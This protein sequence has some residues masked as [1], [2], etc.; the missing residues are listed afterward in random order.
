MSSIRTPSAARRCTRKQREA[1][2]WLA[3]FR[4]AGHVFVHLPDEPF[5]GGA[6]RLLGGLRPTDAPDSAPFGPYG[7]AWVLQAGLWRGDADH[8][9]WRTTLRCQSAVS[10]RAR[11]G[12]RPHPTEEERWRSQLQSEVMSRRAP[13]AAGTA[14]TNSACNRFSHSHPVRTAA[15]PRSGKPSAAATARTILTRIETRT[16]WVHRA[17]SATASSLGLRREKTL[18]LLAGESTTGGARATVSGTRRKCAHRAPPHPQVSTSSALVLLDQRAM[19][20]SSPSEVGLDPL[21]M[22]GS[23]LPWR[24]AMSCP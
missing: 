6:V 16:V 8:P 24:I 2:A 11:K 23:F 12:I 5:H 1:V 13:I 20:A 18:F 9:S 7:A 10:R 4:R 21:R 14:A 3:A 22:R 17:R 19:N 15:G